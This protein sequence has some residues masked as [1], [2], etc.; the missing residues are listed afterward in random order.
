[1]MN[2]APVPL[3]VQPVSL[4]GRWVRLE[5]LQPEHAEELAA[6]A[7]DEEI[8]RYMPRQLRT[9]DDVHDWIAAALHDQAAGTALPFAIIDQATG[10]AVGS[11]RYLDIRPRD[12]GLEIG[13][14][15]LRRS[16]WRTPVNTENIFFSATPS[17]HSAAF[18]CSSR[19]TGS[20]SARGA[21]SSGSAHSSRAFCAITS[22]C[23]MV[24]TETRPITVSSSMS[25]PR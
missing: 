7:A 3:I 16:C 18:A 13:W 17:R 5:P 11:T 15:W 4:A 21:R 23:P 22:F 12:R 20:I 10:I 9:L 25:G 2:T 1:M 19:R 14:T 8:W 6:A 24:H